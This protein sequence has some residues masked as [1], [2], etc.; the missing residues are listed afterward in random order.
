MILKTAANYNDEGGYIEAWKNNDGTTEVKLIPKSGGDDGKNGIKSI[1]ISP[2]ITTTP[3]IDSLFPIYYDDLDEDEKQDGITRFVTAAPDESTTYTVI[4]TPTSEWYAQGT[5]GW[6]EMGEPVKVTGFYEN[7]FLSVDT[8]VAAEPFDGE[9]SGEFIVG[10]LMLSP[11]VIESVTVTPNINGLSE[12][13]AK[14]LPLHITENRIVHIDDLQPAAHTDYSITV[15]PN[16]NAY[17][18]DY[19]ENEYGEQG[20]PV[21][22]TVQ[23]SAV[24]FV[25]DVSG[26]PSVKGTASRMHVEISVK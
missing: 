9:P 1:S 15:T 7:G 8:I 6:G 3:A 11:A 4:V 16:E 17:A 13:I 21:T 18:F 2:A 10:A 23:S 24:S 26:A 20:Q 22:Y 19:A 25:F 12:E 5:N 14:Y